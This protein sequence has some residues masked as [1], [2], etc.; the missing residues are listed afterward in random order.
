VKA[1]DQKAIEIKE[2][3]ED[4]ESA[5]EGT[6]EM[7]YEESKSDSDSENDDG[8][9][10]ANSSLYG[11]ISTKKTQKRKSVRRTSFAA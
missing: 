3:N 9:V 7:S 11:S 10:H 5:L 1:A 8:V 4:S 6:E 2:V